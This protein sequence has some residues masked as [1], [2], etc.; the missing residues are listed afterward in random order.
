MGAVGRIVSAS[1]FIRPEARFINRH[2]D[3]SFDRCRVYQFH[4]LSG[5]MKKGETKMLRADH[6]LKRRICLKV[7]MNENSSKPETGNK[8][9]RSTPRFQS[10]EELKAQ[11]CSTCKSA[12]FKRRE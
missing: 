11:K 7:C 9:K 2:V 8:K 12:S 5:D 4:A 10:L 6:S 3:S 1:D